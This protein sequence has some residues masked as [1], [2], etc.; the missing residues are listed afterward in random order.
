M[1]LLDG[2]P[3]NS[4]L[5]FSITLPTLSESN[6][7]SGFTSF[8]TVFSLLSGDL[9]L[10]SSPVVLSTESLD[11]TPSWPSSSPNKL[12]I[13]FWSRMSLKLK[14]SINNSPFY[15]TAKLQ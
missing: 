3:P 1:P 2:S 14:S 10:E 8:S 6:K 12:S 11:S 5:S 9:F 4:L 7:S 13:S 15:V